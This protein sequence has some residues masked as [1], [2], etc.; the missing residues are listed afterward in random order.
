MGSLYRSQHELIQ[1]FKKGNAPHQNNVELGRHGRYRTNVWRYAGANSFGADRDESLA[2]HPTV[3][4][5]Q[6]LA[7]AI[8]DVTRRGEIVLDGF[9]GSGSTLMACE[10]TGRICRGVEIDPAYIQV[11]IKRWEK[12]TGKTAIR[13]SDGLTFQEVLDQHEAEEV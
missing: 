12:A 6:M 4:P 2:M 10:Q 7:D 1:I 3:K 11:I 5:V 13:E 9:L 8:L